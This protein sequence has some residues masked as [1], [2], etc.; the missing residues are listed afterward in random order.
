VAE[1][2]LTRAATVR[3]VARRFGV[4][5]QASL[6]Q[7]FLVDRSARDHIVAAVGASAGDTVLEIGPGL[8]TLTQGLCDAGAT[9][10]AV[11]IDPACVA[12]LRLTLHRRPTA[13]VVRGD[14]LQTTPERLGLAPGY[15]VAGN[16]PY[17]LT[18][19]LLPR[20]LA[21]DPG[22]RRIVVLVQREVA[23]RVAAEHGG[24]SLATLSV[25]LLGTARHQ[26]DL[27]PEAF[28]PRPRVRSSLL[29]LE[30][31]P[32][33]AA[34]ERQAVLDLARQAFRGRRKQLAV[35][36]GAALGRPAG[37]I[38]SWLTDLGVEPTRRPETLSVA[39][40][41]RLARARPAA[42][43]RPADPLL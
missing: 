28:W 27:G 8:G 26:L 33:A 42:L 30:P 17:S 7:H 12:A 20:L 29:I 16:L 6:G 19:A 11:E 1:L 43:G 18:G 14:I 31:R 35:S 15:L 38:R 32:A 41:L 5:A 39:E 13:R 25:R 40:W 34:P 24:W 10:V 22:P 36:L 4:G 3:A 2:D 21:A 37:E 9:V 23:L